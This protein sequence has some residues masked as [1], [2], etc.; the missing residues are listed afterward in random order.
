MRTNAVRATLAAILAITLLGAT[1][2]AT[3]AH[4]GHRGPA[5]A[6]GVVCTMWPGE[7]GRYQ[8]VGGNHAFIVLVGRRHRIRVIQPGTQGWYR[9]RGGIKRYYTC[10]RPGHP[11]SHRNQR[12]SGP[13]GPVGTLPFYR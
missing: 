5:R 7:G 6:S 8:W 10:E 11:V 1:I 2:T 4:R 13:S 9:M 12:T 3:A